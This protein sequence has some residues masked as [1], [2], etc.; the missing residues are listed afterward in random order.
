MIRIVL[1]WVEK[2]NSSLIFAIPQEEM[3]IAFNAS[4]RDV[5][6]CMSAFLKERKAKNLTP[7]AFAS[8]VAQ[9]RF[10]ETVE[11]PPPWNP[12]KKKRK[13]KKC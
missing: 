9:G 13:C 3:A 10:G 2:K 12:S 5:E 4:E 11:A 6:T 8:F 1:D 7:T